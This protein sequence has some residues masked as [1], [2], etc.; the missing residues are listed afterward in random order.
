MY[1][2]YPG[3]KAGVLDGDSPLLKTNIDMYINDLKTKIV[4]LLD[5]LPNYM[6]TIKDIETNC[7]F[8]FERIYRKSIFDQVYDRSTI[9]FKNNSELRFIDYD[10]YFKHNFIECLEQHDKLHDFCDELEKRV[11]GPC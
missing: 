5:V 3:L 10:N 7:I 6:I 8:S 9:K 1:V 2:K 11:I 4:E